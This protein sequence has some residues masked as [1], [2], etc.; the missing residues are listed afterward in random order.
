MQ[1]KL[2]YWS[3][4]HLVT[5]Q[6]PPMLCATGIICH[7]DL[8]Y[9]HSPIKFHPLYPIVPIN[10]YP[11]L[12]DST[13]PSRCVHSTRLLFFWTFKVNTDLWSDLS[14]LHFLL[15]RVRNQVFELRPILDCEVKGSNFY[16]ASLPCGSQIPSSVET[17]RD[18]IELRN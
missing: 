18:R 15:E 14:F 1:P 13:R 6:S 16:L 3:V 4:L 12:L 5:F 9:P 2:L 17:R 7:H 11:H 10:L 8:S